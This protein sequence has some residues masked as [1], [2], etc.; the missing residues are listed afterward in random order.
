MDPD[1]NL[2]HDMK[3]MMRKE[4]QDH[5]LFHFLFK[6]SFPYVLFLFTFDMKDLVIS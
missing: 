6:D 1:S 3:M 5:L 2:A 4:S